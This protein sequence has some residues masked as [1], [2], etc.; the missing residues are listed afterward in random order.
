MKIQG[1]PDTGASR[2][3][4]SANFLKKHKITFDTSYDTQPLRNASGQSMNCPG[5][6]AITL[7]T[8]DGCS[9][10]CT[11]LISDD[12]VDDLLVSWTDLQNLGRIP[13]GFPHA[14]VSQAT[15]T[16]DTRLS[17]HEKSPPVTHASK[18]EA[19]MSRLKQTILQEFNDVISDNLPSQHSLGVEIWKSWNVSSFMDCWKSSQG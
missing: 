18:V 13:L 6:M 4:I 17:T 3:I 8:E 15:V 2:T 19:D 5:E 16:D 14:V 11:A 9:T 10:A 1:I 7:R 12:L